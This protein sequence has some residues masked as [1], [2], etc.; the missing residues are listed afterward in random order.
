MIHAPAIGRHYI[1][2]FAKIVVNRS[3]GRPSP[4]KICMLLAAL[5]LAL[6]GGLRN[7][8]IAYGPPLLE[9]YR[10]FF[11]AV[12]RPGDHANPYFPFFHLAG[13]LR[14][15]ESSFWHLVPL[16]GREAVVDALTT[17][18]SDA[19]VLRNFVGARLDAELFEL[20][21]HPEAIL[22]LSE[23][24]TQ[25]WFDRG[26]SELQGIALQCHEQSRYERRLR[27]EGTAVPEETRPEPR[28]RDGAFRR[29]VIE[30]YDYRCAASGLR[31]VLDGGEVL[32]EAALIQP[33]AISG[34]DDPRNGLALTP[35]M[36][37][38]MDR[39]LIAPGPD[40]HWHVSRVLDPRIPDAARLV[41]LEGR[42]LFLPRDRSLTPRADVLGW[43]LERLRDSAWRP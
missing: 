1:A 29:L 12:A 9:R 8:L 40:L 13:K 30:A 22:D 36:H 24:L 21:Q 39:N 25:R 6:G 28:V 35:D 43:R 16:P 31:L 42:K 19:D 20:L 27:M 4:H 34:D 41:D 38:A 18:R 3:G 32:V 10:R 33:H 14:G 26:L 11:A 15:G 23:A 2:R 17:A 37:W 7:N 5:D